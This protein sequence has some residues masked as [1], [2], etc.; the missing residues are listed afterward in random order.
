VR[1]LLQKFIELDAY[2]EK[3]LTMPPPGYKDST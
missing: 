1:F 3:E 2:S